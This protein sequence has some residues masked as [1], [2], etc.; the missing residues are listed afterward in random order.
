MSEYIYSK[1]YFPLSIVFVVFIIFLSPHKIFA[2][3]KMFTDNFNDGN[4]SNWV[5][6]NDVPCHNAFWEIKDGMLGMNIVDERCISNIYPNDTLWNNIGNN[7]IFKVDMKF[8]KGMDHNLA[9]RYT[10][11]DN[12]SKFYEIHFQSPND[13]I[14]DGTSDG[15]YLTNIPS[16][17]P[18]G[19]T[20]HIKIIVNKNNIKVYINDQLKRDFISTYDINPSGKIAL[21]V[22]TGDVTS[23]ETWFDNVEVTSIDD[24]NQNILNVPYFSQN[25][26]PWG[27]SEYDHTSLLG[28]TGNNAS[29]D[30]WGCAVTSAAMVLRFHNINELI[31]GTAIDPG[32][33]NSWLKTH[34]GFSYGITQDGWYSGI[35]W[36]AISA[37]SKNIHDAG[38]SSLSLE[39]D[40]L[41]NTAPVLDNDLQQN[42]IPVILHV[43]TKT[44]SPKSIGHYIVAKGKQ[45]QTY[46]INDPE[47]NY[48]LLTNFNNSY[49][50]MIRYIPSNTDL[51]Y[52]QLD[53]NP[54]VQIL[55]TD[56][57]GR[58]SGA[59]YING[60]KQSYNEIPNSKYFLQSPLI[61]PST[62][63]NQNTL[64][65]NFN[66]FLL[67]KPQNGLYTI[68]ISSNKTTDYLMNIALFEKDGTSSLNRI[69]GLISK[70]N[71]DFLD[72]DYNNEIQ[73]HLN[74]VV[75]IQSII[76][77]IR[78]GIKLKLINETY[79]NGL[80]LTLQGAQS[81]FKA[82]RKIA[83]QLKLK[84]FLGSITLAKNTLLKEPLYAILS[85]DANYLINHL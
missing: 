41:S 80:I 58:K 70:N 60:L 25:D 65:I 77:D 51:S 76:Q 81:D 40:A 39:L 9:F 78:E 83:V 53:I 36:N 44:D 3:Q 73:S 7:Y 13:F 16:N 56:S 28:L 34:N 54:S 71:N 32:S 50:Q 19:D 20:Y 48:Q 52:M 8:V 38:K 5:I 79:G 29:M 22:G 61:N 17:Y 43:T 55:V 24:D 68:T 18:V 72:I 21:R 33:V 45:D 10:F 12:H 2:D 66:E 75:S 49:D 35:I 82:G 6:A 27:P 64:G 84:A 67:Q 47:W 69:Y 46:A 31:D 11:T 62:G 14:L 63:N 1:I 59:I 26:I 30:W 15:D 23:S 74:R 42:H 57:L 4:F 85:A 37:L